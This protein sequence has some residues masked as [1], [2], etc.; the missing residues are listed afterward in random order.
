MPFSR[1]RR[2][3]SGH[4]ALSAIRFH[5]IVITRD[6][7]FLQHLWWS[8]ARYS[9]KLKS[10]SSASHYSRRI[11][12]VK[13][14]FSISSREFP[15]QQWRGS[16]INLIPIDKAEPFGVST[17]LGGAAG[18]HQFW[19]PHVS[20][21]EA[22]PAKCHEILKSL[23]NE[24]TCRIFHESIFLCSLVV[25]DYKAEKG[26]KGS[27]KVKVMKKKS[28]SSDFLEGKRVKEEKII[29]QQRT[30]VGLL[31]FKPST[32]VIHKHGAVSCF[33]QKNIFFHSSSEY[34]RDWKSSIYSHQKTTKGK[35]S[36]TATGSVFKRSGNKG[37][38]FY[39]LVRLIRPSILALNER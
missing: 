7:A 29:A 27:K 23:R 14:A 25:I 32:I 15:S 38:Q 6:E 4:V 39:D 11:G 12:A 8:P 2:L 3:G 30:E 18:L 31:I 10:S 21:R 1:C 34:A 37:N 19:F 24:F 5:F 16:E 13:F 22:A 36:N 28:Y 20:F 26:W 33:E 9:S 17:F 35:N